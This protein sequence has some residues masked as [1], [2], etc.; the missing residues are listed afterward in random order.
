MRHCGR[1]RTR[2]HET[3]WCRAHLAFLEEQIVELDQQIVRHIEQA[4]LQRDYALLQTI[5]GVNKLAAAAIVA[6][7]GTK[8]DCLAGQRRV[9]SAERFYV[10]SSHVTPIFP[11]DSRTSGTWGLDRFGRASDCRDASTLV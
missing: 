7:L 3:R 1:N 6:E 2:C 10:T 4:Q 8:M 11:D 9:D 5:P